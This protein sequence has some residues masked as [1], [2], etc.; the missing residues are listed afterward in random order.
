[1]TSADDLSSR[2]SRT[3]AV[4]QSFGRRARDYTR[5][6]QLQQHSARTLAAFLH[7]H[8]G[9]PA[10]PLVE[11]GCGTGLLTELLHE[12]GRPYLA[13]D[14][15]PEML[16]QC[17]TRLGDQR[18]GLSFAVLDGQTAAFAAPPAAPPTAI[19][20]N[21]TCQWFADPVEGLARLARQTPLLAFSVPLAGSFPEWEAAFADLGRSSGL[22]PLP[23]EKDI[24]AALADLSPQR[25]VHEVEERPQHFP[26]AKAFADSFRLIGADQPRQ[27]Y[28]PA[29][30]RPVLKR[31]ASGLDATVRILYCLVMRDRL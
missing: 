12:P 28:T 5:H 22:L 31:F 14:L 10:G 26:S 23:D 19:V 24:L 3:Q 2:M 7:E 25:L 8:G 15:S 13:T 6:A 16:E 27:G 18:Q 11:I 29:P 20:S 1:M 9:L 4:A 17:R 21:L 30:I